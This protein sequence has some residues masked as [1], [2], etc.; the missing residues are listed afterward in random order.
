M[1]RFPTARLL[2]VII[3]ALSLVLKLAL[4]VGVACFSVIANTLLKKVILFMVSV[5]DQVLI[6]LDSFMLGCMLD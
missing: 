6:I 3:I 5:G 2:A 1:E 4:L